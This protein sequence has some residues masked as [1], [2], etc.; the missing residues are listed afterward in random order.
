[1]IT[2]DPNLA[3]GREIGRIAVGES[4]P[5]TPIVRAEKVDQPRGVNAVLVTRMS[6]ACEV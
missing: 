3:A 2:R 1:M 6:K 4:Q 5:E